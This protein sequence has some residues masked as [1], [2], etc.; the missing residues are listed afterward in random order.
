MFLDDEEDGN[1]DTIV[2]EQGRRRDEEGKNWCHLK[3]E[4]LPDFCYT[5]GRMGHTD[6]DC[7][8]KL[9]KGEEAQYGQWLKY[10]PEG[11]AMEERRRGGELVK[12]LFVEDEARI[13]LATPIREE[14]ED[15]YAWFSDSKGEFSVKS[16]YKLYVA[17]R[18]AGQPS[19]SDPKPAGWEWTEIWGLPCQPK[20][21]QFLWRLAHNSLPLKRNI[22]RRGMECNTLYV[23]CGRLDEDAA[24]LFLKCKLVKRVWR[25]LQ[26]EDTRQQLCECMDGMELLHK[27]LRLPEEKTIRVPCLLWK[28]WAWRN[29][30]NAGDK[31]S[32]LEKL[33]AEINHWALESL[34]LCRPELTTPPITTQQTWRRPEGDI[35]KINCDGAFNASQG[36]GGWGFIVRDDAGDVRGSGAGFL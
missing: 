21:H 27:T 2:K 14:F 8:T 31:P 1:G 11:S 32:A 6:R 36:T 24:H 3:Y 23:C 13:I 10:V 9:K 28:W 4:F 7:K 30:V 20:I 5:C 17:Q 34:A 29:K 35:L 33:P 15:F 18:D 19:A 16:A 22:Q 12:S 25:E 26:L